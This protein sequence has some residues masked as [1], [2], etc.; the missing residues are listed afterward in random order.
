MRREKLLTLRTGST[1]WRRRHG[2]NERPGRNNSNFPARPSKRITCRGRPLPQGRG[3]DGDTASGR[4]FLAGRRS[5]K[6]HLGLRSSLHARNPRA[7][8]SEVTITSGCG[9][10]TRIFQSSRPPPHADPAAVSPGSPPHTHTPAHPGRS[11]SCRGAVYVTAAARRKG[12]GLRQ[13]STAPS[14][15]TPAALERRN[16]TPAAEAEPRRRA[17]RRREDPARRP[18]TCGDSAPDPRRR[19][20]AA[21]GRRRLDGDGEERPGL[22]GG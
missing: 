5:A 16:A 11:P 2:A 19:P 17:A 21:E 22:A 8:G 6:R 14:W 7:G 1:T 20:G 13:S 3:R 4:A 9:G 12:P 15:K 10:G 18:L